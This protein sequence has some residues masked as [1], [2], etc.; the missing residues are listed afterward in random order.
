MH[1]STLVVLLAA[2]VSA[3]PT[4]GSFS[5]SINYNAPQ[6]L[7]EDEAQQF[8]QTYI[9]VISKTSPTWK[10][11]AERIFSDANYKEVSNSIE[12]VQGKFPVSQTYSLTAWVTE[13]V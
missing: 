5:L 12:S 9:G 10:Q 1:R 2:A 3:L 11:D 4:P 6:C 7:Q 13:T 8:L